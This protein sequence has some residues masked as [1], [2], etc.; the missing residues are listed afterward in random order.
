MLANR[1]VGCSD[2]Q[3]FN[4]GSTDAVSTVLRGFPQVRALVVGQYG[5]ASLD[6]HE[7]LELAVDSATSRDWRYL[8]ARSQSEARG[9]YI[10][11]TPPAC[12]ALG[13]A[14]SF[15]RWHVT[16]CAG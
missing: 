2:V 7:L 12:D 1:T 6:V 14:Y 16:A 3:A 15:A 10:D 11:T 9:Y 5:E 4:A 13:D 8:G